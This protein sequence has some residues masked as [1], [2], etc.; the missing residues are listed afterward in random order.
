MDKLLKIMTSPNSVPAVSQ[1]VIQGN[2][3]RIAKEGL[4]LEGQQARDFDRMNPLVPV[5]MSHE[6]QLRYISKQNRGLRYYS[7]IHGDGGGL[8]IA[9]DGELTRNPIK[10]TEEN[11][12]LYQ[13]VFPDEPLPNE[14][15]L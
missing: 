14:A 7:V 1:D 8:F 11:K 12:K 15:Q 6:D 5:S 13:E 10:W 4:D 2:F 3:D 9:L